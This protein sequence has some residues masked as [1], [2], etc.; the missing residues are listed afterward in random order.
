MGNIVIKKPFRVV[1]EGRADAAF[2]NRL[3]DARGLGNFE[4][5][6]A[7]TANDVGRCAGK[8]GITDTLLA[9]KGV[10]DLYPRRL[11]GIVI[12]V[13]SD[14]DPDKAFQSVRQAIRMA[15]AQLPVPSKLLQPEVDPQGT[16]PSIVVMCVPWVDAPGHLDSLLFES[17]RTTHN[18]LMSPIDDFLPTDGTSDTR[19]VSR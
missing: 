8:S 17:M 2:F 4:A 7:R 3:F 18:D 12:A 19:L 16:D 11:Q 6:C 10:A 9:L 5:E 15:K 13:D 14:D 1:C